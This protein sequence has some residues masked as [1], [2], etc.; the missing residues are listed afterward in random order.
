MDAILSNFSLS[1]NLSLIAIS[2]ILIPIILHLLNPNNARTVWIAHID[3]IRNTKLKR[4]FQTKWLDK[5]LLLIRLMIFCLLALVLAE[6]VFHALPNSVDQ[7]HIFISQDW[8]LNATE[9]DKKALL[10]KQRMP[11]QV[12]YFQLEKSAKPYLDFLSLENSTS[13]NSN[14]IGFENRRNLQSEGGFE[15][16]S[17]QD[18]ILELNHRQTTPAATEI[19]ITNKEANF[20]LE[21]LNLELS[22]KYELNILKLPVSQI[23]R[24]P[25]IKL[26]NTE[27]D[28]KQYQT[29]IQLLRIAIDTLNIELQTEL[30][31][32]KSVAYAEPIISTKSTIKKADLIFVLG[33]RGSGS[34]KDKTKDN[35]TKIVYVEPSSNGLAFFIRNHMINHWNS[36]AP[37]DLLQIIS[38]IIE[39]TPIST[40]QHRVNENLFMPP[41]NET[42]R[43]SMQNG[44]IYSRALL[45][46]ILFLISLLWL[47]ERR[48]SLA[49]GT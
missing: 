25:I 32:D 31:V 18:Y 12:K 17:S 15:D 30:S 22:Q 1:N 6:P 21:T 39:S 41:A 49:S 42:R 47:A 20:N 16:V 26:I 34:S 2:A 8:L 11:Q 7:R 29:A 48:L 5:L 35:T 40:M 33:K 10:L 4:V 46:Y 23:V 38:Q 36:E 24:K 37:N 28:D 45:K 43:G 44:I 3:F 13:D 19:Y 9:F 14:K 27:N